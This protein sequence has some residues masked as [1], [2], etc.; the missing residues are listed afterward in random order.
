M[1]LTR[2]TFVC[3]LLG[4]CSREAPLPAIAAGLPDNE[5]AGQRIFDERLRSAYP[6]GTPIATLKQALGEQGFKVSENRADLHRSHFPCDIGWTV[7]WK[8]AGTLVA[9]VQGF[10]GRACP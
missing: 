2:L 4:A 6:K 10:Y 9:N 3:C 8:V 1:K 5:Q 7:Q